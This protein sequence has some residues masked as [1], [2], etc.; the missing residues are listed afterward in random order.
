MAGDARGPSILLPAVASGGLPAVL[1]RGAVLG[2]LAYGT[3]AF[4]NHA[5]LEGWTAALVAADVAWGIVLTA[6]AAACG[7]WATRLG[8]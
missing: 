8:S 4:T 2:A 5:M 1:M 6:A 3:Y 7:L